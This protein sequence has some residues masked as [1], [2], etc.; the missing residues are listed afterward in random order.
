M[1]P[2]RRSTQTVLSAPANSHPS[3]HRLSAAPLDS[4]WSLL[5]AG[6][7]LR[8]APDI[9]IKTQKDESDV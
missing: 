4:V 8:L 3:P 7:A 6:Y 5:T 9:L 2:A 1:Q